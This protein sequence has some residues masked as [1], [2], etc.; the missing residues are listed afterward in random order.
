MSSYI[1]PHPLHQLDAKDQKSRNLVS[2]ET[3]FLQGSVTSGLFYLVSGTVNLNRMTKNGHS[4]LI[5]RACAGD[6]FAEASL[7][8]DS[9]HCTATAVNETVVIECQRDAVLQLLD[10][11]IAFSRAMISRFALQIQEGRRRVELLSMHSAEERIVAAL[12]D[13][14]LIDDIASFAEIVGLAPETVYRTL[15][16]LSEEGVVKKISRGVYQALH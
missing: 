8:S 4:A 10:T 13:G 11:D 6:T 5:H 3:L 9:Y 7:F 2:G 1:L 15:G 14:L 16:K 12:G